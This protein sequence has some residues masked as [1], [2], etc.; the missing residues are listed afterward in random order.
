MTTF[1]QLNSASLPP[2]EPFTDQLRLAVGVYV[3][4]FKGLLMRATE[5]DRRCYLAWCAERGPD[6]LSPGGRTW[7]CTSGGCRRSAGSG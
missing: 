4:R 3:A 6:Q 7:R 1:A 5:S 2:P